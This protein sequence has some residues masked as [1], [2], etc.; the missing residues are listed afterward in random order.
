MFGRSLVA[1]AV[2]LTLA[3]GSPSV[4]QDEVSKSPTAVDSTPS[5]AREV[6]SSKPAE[7]ESVPPPPKVV[8]REPRVL[9][10]TEASNQKC[11]TELARLRKPGGDFEAMKSRGWKIGPGPEN[12]VQIVDCQ[13][14]PEIVEKLN[15]REFPTVACIE[16]GEIV[17]SFKDG[18]STPLDSWTFGFLL[19]GKNERPP[20]SIPEPVRVASTGAYRLRGNHWSIDGD[21]NPSRVTVLSHLRGPNHYYRIAGHWKLEN[22]SLEELRSLHDDIHESEQTSSTVSSSSSRSSNTNRSPKDFSAR[23]R[24]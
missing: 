14:I 15:V 5:A 7:T 21:W 12:H 19:N 22:W 3:A 20:A 2:L 18:C 11:L 1:A 8:P 23:A 24:P 10:I 9:F 13:A 17:R 6:T 4:A 16:K